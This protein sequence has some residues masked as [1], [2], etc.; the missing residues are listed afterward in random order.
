MPDYDAR[1]LEFALNALWMIPAVALA[2]ALGDRVVLRRCR[3]AARESFWLAAL[4][5]AIA[6]PLA[7]RLQPRHAAPAYRIWLDTRGTAPAAPARSTPWWTVTAA[8]VLAGQG[9][10]LGWRCYRLA[11]LDEQRA[12]VPLTY[13]RRIL[14]PAR[15]AA[16]A[17][18]LALAAARAHEEAHV[19]RRDFAWNLALEVLALPVAWHPVFAWMR[20]RHADLRELACDELA[21]GNFS[22]PRTYAQGLLEAA[23][24]LVRTEGAAPALG[25]FDHTS[26]E[27][28]IHMLTEFRSFLSPARSRALALGALVLLAGGATAGTAFAV[29]VED[30]EKPAS[31]TTRPRLI[32]KQ[33]PTYTDAG[34]A[35][36]VCGA[37][38]LDVVVNESGLIENPRIKRGLEPSLDEAA[39]EAV[40]Q[41]RFEPATRDGQ[42]V[43]VSATV[44]VNFRLDVCKN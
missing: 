5:V 12:P 35:A 28:R 7:P 8:V 13:G 29:A 1:V 33:N 43:P 34:R 24:T 26:F 32:A 31:R 36:Q 30:Q 39:K 38:V 15:F 10:R 21:A 2:A 20:R 25:V 40:A 9:I 14:I 22:D 19:A 17:T 42:P 37:V 3:P 6:W 41:W 44:E 27:V 4:L 23:R 16:N 11:R 18:P